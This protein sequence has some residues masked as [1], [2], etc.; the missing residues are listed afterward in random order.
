ME[1]IIASLLF[2][3][4]NAGTYTVFVFDERLKINKQRKIFF[5]SFF[6]VASIVCF[7]SG[8]QSLGLIR[9]SISLLLM[10][11]VVLGMY[12]YFFSK[13]FE[14]RGETFPETIKK[15]VVFGLAPVFTLVATVIQILLVYNVLD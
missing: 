4:L 5:Y 13:F 10:Y 15:I 2:V 12:K 3:G 14:L 11:F 8:N 1:K 6:A 9:P 7:I